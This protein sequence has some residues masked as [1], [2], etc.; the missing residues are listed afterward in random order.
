MPICATTMNTIAPCVAIPSIAINRFAMPASPAIAMTAKPICAARFPPARRKATMPHTDNPD[1]RGKVLP[2]QRPQANIPE[3]P[4][5]ESER[6]GE[7]I[8]IFAALIDLDTPDILRIDAMYACLS[9]DVES[10]ARFF[11]LL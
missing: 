7:R 6:Y 5:G 2:F 3:F 9:A 11:W 10:L 4:L 1:A 8:A